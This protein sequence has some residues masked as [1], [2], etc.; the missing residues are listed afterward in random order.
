MTRNY[1]I[2][3]PLMF[4]CVISD[5][6]MWSIHADTIYTRKLRRRGVIIKQDLEVDIMDDILVKN[7][8][9]T[10]LTSIPLTSSFR[11]VIDRT[12]HTGHKGFPIVDAAGRLCGVV[13]HVD[14][15]RASLE[16]R[17]DDT[18]ERLTERPVVVTF[19]D[20]NL[21]KVLRKFFENRI[22]HIPVVS[23]QDRK[24]LLGFMTRSDILKVRREK[25]KAT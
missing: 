3:L 7:V 17:L 25:M 22:V 15:K 24:E 13:S 21:G 18:V 19:P 2:I 16:S 10:D 8:M 9:S 23:R 4:A 11:D 12:V 5:F 1:D 6:L 20:E 14:V